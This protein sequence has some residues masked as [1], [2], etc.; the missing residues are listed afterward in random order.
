MVSAFQVAVTSCIS[1]NSILGATFMIV[2]AIVEA[3]YQETNRFYLI[4]IGYGEF[5]EH[6][7]LG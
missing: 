2:A 7:A 1:E 6:F 4:I 5:A 3:S